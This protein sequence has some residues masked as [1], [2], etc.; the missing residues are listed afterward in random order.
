M[1][2]I[3]EKVTTRPPSGGGDLVDPLRP[4][5]GLERA[6]QSGLEVIP[7]SHP[8]GQLAYAS[9]GVLRVTTDQGTWVVPP[10]QAVW[11]PGGIRHQ[12]TAETDCTVRHLHIDPTAAARLPGQC[13]VLEVS[14]LLRE[15][16]L[17]VSRFG[18]LYPADGPE[19]RL[20]A[21]FLDEL[22]ALQ[23]SLL[24]LPLAQDRRV[25]RVMDGLM[26]QPDSEKGLDEWATEVGA[27]GRTLARL[28]QRETGM[29]FSE[30]RKQLR[31]QEAVNRLARGEP[32][33][34]VALALGY[35]SPS[36]F[37]AMFR[38]TLGSPPGQ[39]CRD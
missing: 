19:Q 15:L 34:E 23:P 35:R 25:R 31:L 9:E 26:R 36:A 22:G 12:V 8:R 6:M 24:Y 37:V 7:H 27:S 14:S 2:M 4:V 18:R 20:V 16:I 1:T 28:F 3:D 38:K 11:I 32:V 21:V 30:W 17:R 29:K 39:Y 33:T 13:S 10:S 5:I